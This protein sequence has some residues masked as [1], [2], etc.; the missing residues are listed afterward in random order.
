MRNKQGRHCL[1]D[2]LDALP[3]PHTSGNGRPCIVHI[4]NH[5]ANLHAQPNELQ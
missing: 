4:T 2:A 3:P 5:E 1:L